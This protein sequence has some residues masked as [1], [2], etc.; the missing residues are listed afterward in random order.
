MF[1]DQGV[2]HFFTVMFRICKLAYREI[3]KQLEGQKITVM[4]GEYCIRMPFAPHLPVFIVLNVF[5]FYEC[6][7]QVQC[8]DLIKSSDRLIPLGF[9][10]NA[11]G[12]KPDVPL[13]N[14]PVPDPHYFL[15]KF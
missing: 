11:D 9:R 15:L 8:R 5:D 14:L 4:M 1:F 13:V 10:A 2:A 3:H 6:L 7:T 12:G